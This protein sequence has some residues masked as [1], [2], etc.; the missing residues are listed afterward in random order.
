MIKIKIKDEKKHL[1][2]K[3][4]KYSNKL[5]R[6]SNENIN[7]EAT[8]NQPATDRYVMTQTELGYRTECC[9]IHR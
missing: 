6:L 4:M 3:E 1:F 2:N 7:I 9:E 8:G 5:N